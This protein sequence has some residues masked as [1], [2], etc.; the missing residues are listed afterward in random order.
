MAAPG[1]VRGRVLDAATRRPVRAF[2]VAVEWRLRRARPRATAKRT[3]RD[4]AGAFVWAELPAREVSVFVSAAGYVGR[5]VAR[6]AVPENDMT[7]LLEIALEADV[8]RAAS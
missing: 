4:P 7:E 1:T 5:T 6:V 8:P 3:C 2:W